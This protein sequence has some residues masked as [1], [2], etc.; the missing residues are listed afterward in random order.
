[1]IRVIILAAACLIGGASVAHAG[2]VA[3]AFTAIQ[4]ALAAGGFAA[5]AIRIVGGLALNAI[6]AALQKRAAR[7]AAANQR[8]PGIRTSVTLTGGLNPDGM[9]AGSYATGGYLVAPPLEHGANN[10]YNSAVIDLSG[11]PLTGLER[12]FVNGAPIDLGAD[13]AVIEGDSF[14]KPALGRFADHLWGQVL[15]WHP[16]GGRPD[17]FG[18]GRGCRAARCRGLDRAHIGHE[19]RHQRGRLWLRAV[20][21][22]W[23]QRHDPD[24]A[25][26]RDV[27]GAGFGHHKPLA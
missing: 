22:G 5:F 13:D 19:Q 16:D 4:G 17:A 26:W 23:R 8:D 11:V 7:R 1:M 9:I 18:A 6:G 12:V 14:G 15:R 3:A 27:D 25:R 10:I 21:R 2:I 24:I 20:G